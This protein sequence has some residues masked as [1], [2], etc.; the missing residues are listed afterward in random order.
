MP[1]PLKQYLSDNRSMGDQSKQIYTDVQTALFNCPMYD[2]LYS[3]LRLE[4]M[5]SIKPLILFLHIIPMY[6][7]MSY[8]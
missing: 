2:C 4:V 6:E 5:D 8:T 3:G 1:K 7:F